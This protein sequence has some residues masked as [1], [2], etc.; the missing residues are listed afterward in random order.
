MSRPSESVQ[1]RRGGG[2]AAIVFA[3][4]IAALLVGCGKK[5]NPV[6]PPDEPSTYPRG[7]PSE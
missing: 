1:G 7:Y 6:P 5:G 4:M 2:A 3:V